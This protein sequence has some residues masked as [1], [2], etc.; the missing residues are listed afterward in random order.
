MVEKN[1]AVTLSSCFLPCVM[2]GLVRWAERRQ[3]EI[4]RDGEP[5]TEE[6]LKLALRAGVRFPERIRIQVQEKIPMPDLGGSASWRGAVAWALS[7]RV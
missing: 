6:E 3:V 4:L 2:P 1:G 7:R 5:P